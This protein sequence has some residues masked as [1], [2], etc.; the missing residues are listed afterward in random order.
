MLA[1]IVEIVG[2]GTDAKLDYAT[3]KPVGKFVTATSGLKT[4]VENGMFWSEIRLGF[5]EPGGTSL[6]RIPKS[7]PPRGGGV[8]HATNFNR[9][10]KRNPQ[11]RH[12]TRN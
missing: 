8:E 3:T 11:L 6:P 4:G 10:V 1:E 5:R 12:C 7:T 2:F 9:G